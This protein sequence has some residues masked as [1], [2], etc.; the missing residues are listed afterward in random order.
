[1]PVLPILEARVASAFTD[2]IRE[3]YIKFHVA[4]GRM[5]AKADSTDTSSEGAGVVLDHDDED[6]CQTEV[7]QWRA[8]RTGKAFL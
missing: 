4:E 6:E 8:A 5:R 2:L 7:A 1:M 3:E